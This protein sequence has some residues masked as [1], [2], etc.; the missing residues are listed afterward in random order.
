VQRDYEGAHKHERDGGM[1]NGN[2]AVEKNREV[3]E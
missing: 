2:A 1:V 3:T